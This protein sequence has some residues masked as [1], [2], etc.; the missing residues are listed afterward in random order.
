[1][2][3]ATIQTYFLPSF[4]PFLWSFLHSI[5]PPSLTHPS[6]T[7]QKTSALTLL[8]QM[9]PLSKLARETFS[10]QYRSK[11]KHH[12]HLGFGKGDGG[13]RFP[14]FGHHSIVSNIQILLF[15]TFLFLWPNKKPIVPVG[16]LEFQIHFHVSLF[17]LQVHVVLSLHLLPSLTRCEQAAHK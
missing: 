11:F 7:A 13:K 16:S 2:L 3:Y 4:S 12:R 6:D 17:S 15:T 14:F 5:H 8:L 10:S 9:H 1:M